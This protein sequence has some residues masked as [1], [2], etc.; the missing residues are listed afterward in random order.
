M[1]SQ[2]G[3]GSYSIGQTGA[4]EDVKSRTSLMEKHKVPQGYS[5]ALPIHA[6]GGREREPE[7]ADSLTPFGMTFC[8]KKGY[9]EDQEFLLFLDLAGTAAAFTVGRNDGGFV[10]LVRAGSSIGIAR[11]DIDKRL[12]AQLGE[13]SA[14]RGL[15]A[16]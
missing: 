6:K 12:L 4:S 14:R 1:N 7:N 16:L 10:A 3:T 15:Q 9:L 5:P 8:R 11:L 2:A 13:I